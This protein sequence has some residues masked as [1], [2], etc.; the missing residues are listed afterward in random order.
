MLCMMKPKSTMSVSQAR[1]AF[2]QIVSEVAKSGVSVT[3]SRYGKPLAMIIPV[4]DTKTSAYPLRGMPLF[5]A[6]DFNA[7][8]DHLWEA[9][10]EN[11]SLGYK[12]AEESIPYGT[13]NRNR[14]KLPITIRM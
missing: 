5:I 1:N 14:A 13:K 8:L 9:L 10:D 3:V 2:P 12:V 4:P 7:P 6:E 11:D